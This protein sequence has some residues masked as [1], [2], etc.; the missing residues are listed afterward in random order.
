MVNYRHHFWKWRKVTSLATLIIHREMK[1]WPTNLL[2]WFWYLGFIFL[3]LQ[4]QWWDTPLEQSQWG[5]SVLRPTSHTYH[6]PEKWKEDGFG[7]N[8]VMLLLILCN[9]L[10]I[11][12][13]VC[14]VVSLLT[15]SVQLINTPHGITTSYLGLAWWLSG[16]ESACQS[17]RH[18]FD[19]WSGKIPHAS[20]Q[21]SP[22]ATVIGPVLWSLGAPTTE[23]TCHNYWS[24][25]T[26]E[27]VS[28][29]TATAKEPLLPAT[30]EKPSQQQRP[31]TAK[32]KV[33]Q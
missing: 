32:T 6:I 18:R 26:L 17:R 30:R 29:H 2:A 25:C 8:V 27:P 9:L 16:K 24:P 21:L 23:S 33:N 3:P 15:L 1:A 5:C 4:R 13:R 19:P 7:W 10:M 14:W 31:S 12:W 22:S 11:T 20:E 28:L